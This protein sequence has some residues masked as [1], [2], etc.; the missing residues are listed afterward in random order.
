M[1]KEIY[2]TTS[3]ESLYIAIAFCDY[4]RELKRSVKDKD[5]Y[6]RE[7]YKSLIE[8]LEPLYSALYDSATYTAR[9]ARFQ[10]S[11]E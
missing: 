3:E 10:F 1:K 7:Y 6:N 4:Y 5:C 8:R 11:V 2:T 9:A